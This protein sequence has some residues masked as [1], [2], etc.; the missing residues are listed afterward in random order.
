MGGIIIAQIF[1]ESYVG[2]CDFKC[3]HFNMTVCILQGLAPIMLLATKS[4]IINIWG[5]AAYMPGTA[6]TIQRHNVNKSISLCDC[7]PI[8]NVVNLQ[9]TWIIV[10]KLYH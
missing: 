10:R 9:V 4:T 8:S 3:V 1:K 7:T 2:K 6:R 5:R